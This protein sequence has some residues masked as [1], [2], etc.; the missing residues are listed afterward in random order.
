[1]KPFN[2][3]R[4]LAGDPVV[5]ADGDEYIEFRH[6]PSARDGY[7]VV[8]VRKHSGYLACFT[9]DARDYPGHPPLLFMAPKKRTVWGRLLRNRHDGVLFFLHTVFESKELADRIEA[10]NRSEIVGT[11]PIEIEE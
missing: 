9:E 4:A 11:Y 5:N 10:N 3:E 8:C 2:L 6:L 7:Q 1:M